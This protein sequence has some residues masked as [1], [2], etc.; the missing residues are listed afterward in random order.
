MSKILDLRQKR[1]DVWAKAKA[2]LDA[3]GV[4]YQDRH[5]VEANPTAEELAKWVAESGLELRKFFNTSGLK[6]KALALKEKLPA[7]SDAEKLA[8][9]AS[10]G[11][12]VKRPLL[13]GGGKVLVGFKPAEWEAAL[14]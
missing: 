7:M 13:I 8:L 10:D 5:I 3:A 2:F 4:E 12:L 6:Y 1:S 11:M 14:K 9:L